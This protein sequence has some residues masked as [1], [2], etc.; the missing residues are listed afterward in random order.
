LS[1]IPYNV[2][3]KDLATGVSVSQKDDSKSSW[4]RADFE[5]IDG[6]FLGKCFPVF[7]STRA[8]FGMGGLF[9]LASLL[10]GDN[11]HEDACQ[12]LPACEAIEPHKG[13]ACVEILAKE[14][15][16]KFPVYQFQQLLE[17]A[18]V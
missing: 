1:G 9:A 4:I 13:S 15:K 14:N 2:L 8:A 16:R 7:W 6:D 10:S 5:I 12:M 17:G 3:L 18:A 11:S